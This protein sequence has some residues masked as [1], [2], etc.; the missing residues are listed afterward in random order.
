MAVIRPSRP[1]YKPEDNLTVAGQYYVVCSAVNQGVPNEKYPGK[2]L[3]AI[4]FTL[5][6][7]RFPKLKGKKT[8]IVCGETIYQDRLTGRK[9]HLLQYAEMMGVM[10]AK[11]GYDPETHL[12]QYY[13]VGCEIHSGKAMVRTI[14]PMPH[15]SVGMAASAKL[16]QTAEMP[17]APSGDDVVPF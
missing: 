3:I 10:D 6:D 9:S 4:E 5:V 17:A 15:P 13:M 2:T 8:A 7:E 11:R 1:Q 16:P 14:M 12:D